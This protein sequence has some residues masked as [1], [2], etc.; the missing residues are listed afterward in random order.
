MEKLRIL[1]HGYAAVPP[2]LFIFCGN[3]I[4]KP[5]GPKHSRKLRGKGNQI[6]NFF[7]GLHEDTN[8]PNY[9]DLADL[10]S[11]FPSLVER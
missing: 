11:E 1:F 3:F 4:S 6:P 2:T 9:H 10:I 8:I 5:F 7:I